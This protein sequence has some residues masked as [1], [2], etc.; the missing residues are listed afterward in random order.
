MKNG[1]HGGSDPLSQTDE[2][3]KAVHS[4]EALQIDSVLESPGARRFAEDSTTAADGVGG[5]ERSATMTGD[6]IETLGATARAA[7]SSK[8]EARAAGAV[9]KSVAQGPAASEEQ[10]AHREML[11]GVVGHSVWPTSP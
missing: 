8:V 6:L 11:Q 4:T 5:G 10:V 9:P 7:E 1:G 2:Q 3:P